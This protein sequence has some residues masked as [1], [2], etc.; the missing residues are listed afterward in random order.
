MVPLGAVAVHVNMRM[1]QG[2]SAAC[3]LPTGQITHTR[4]KGAALALRPATVGLPG[5]VIAHA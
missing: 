2:V 5:V 1:W 4:V 3:R